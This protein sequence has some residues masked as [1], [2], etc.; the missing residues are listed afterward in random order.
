ML[1]P[2]HLLRTVREHTPS[3]RV[4]GAHMSREELAEAVA[5]WL[6]ERD[7]KGRK[8]AFDGNH[9]GKLERGAVRRPRQHYVAA[10][11]AVLSA[12]EAELGFA[13]GS[14]GALSVSDADWN[15]ALIE[16]SVETITRIDLAAT[17][18]H[19]LVAAALAGA[20]LTQPLQ[21]WL[22][23]LTEAAGSARH[24]DAFTPPEVEALE[25]LAVQI[26]SWTTGRNG[27]LARKAVVAQLSEL[28]ERLRHAPS[29][30]LTRRA[31]LVTSQLADTV[32]SMSWDAGEHHAAQRY[33]V[34]AVQLAKLA[35][36]DE[37]AAVALAALGR[38]C[39][40]LGRPADGLEVVQLA[41]YGTR[42]SANP[43]LRAMLAT[44]EGW[45]YAQRGEVRAFHRI[46][47]LAQDHFAEIVVPDSC[48]W[49]G[50]F[51]AAEM[52]GVIGARF[53]D[54]ARHDPRQARH[55]QDHIER[56][57]RLRDPGR[58]R[59]RAFDLIGLARVHLITRDLERAAAL[60]YEALPL[61]QNWMSGR[62]GI[63]LG[64][65]HRESSRFVS[66]PVVRDVRD[67]IRGVMTA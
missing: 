34:L 36:D 30:Q 52:H 38:Q 53:R 67:A 54:L 64:D 25:R 27:A 7:V 11:C 65:F 19:A 45:A 35:G 31:V 47:G 56:A 3:R 13:E 15:R 37:L 63:K 62:V 51:D 32:A 20:A 26:R 4:A 42:R 40:D 66:V 21:R 22:E 60:I 55:A 61:T 33:Y 43:R 29:G 59:N 16:N 10:L 5:L 49:V 28:N 6:A 58:L 9:L 24:H 41:Q 8:V 50:N 48:R 12:T 46:V 2:N 44:R 17:R 1:Q 14:A 23:P 18:R 57:L 39:Y